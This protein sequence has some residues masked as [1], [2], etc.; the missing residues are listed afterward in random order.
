MPKGVYTRVRQPLIERFLE[1]VEPFG[2][3]PQ[4]CPEIG[5]CW[6][7]L[8][9]IRHGYGAFYAN[10]RMYGAHVV[11]YYLARLEPIQESPPVIMHLC[12]NTTCVRPG[13]LL[14]GTHRANVADKIAKGREPRGVQRAHVKLTDAD[15][16]IIRQCYSQGGVSQAQLAQVHGV[17]QSLIWRVVNRKGWTH[18]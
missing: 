11:A 15:V 6:L 4:H 3:I 5:R 7:W 10:G 1:K 8:S 13:H 18:L 2:P 17:T 16:I 12:D 14:A 9:A